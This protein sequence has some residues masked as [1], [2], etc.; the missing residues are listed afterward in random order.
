MVCRTSTSIQED[1]TNKPGKDLGYEE[2]CDQMCKMS[3]I[4]W[5]LRQVA[6]GKNTTTYNEPTSEI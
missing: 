2:I 1:C 4:A 6:L 3:K 5:N